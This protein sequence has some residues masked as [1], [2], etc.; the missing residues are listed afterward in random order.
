MPTERYDFGCNVIYLFH[1]ISRACS[2]LVCSVRKL[3]TRW[4]TTLATVMTNLPLG[5]SSLLSIQQATVQAARSQSSSQPPHSFYVP[6][7]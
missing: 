3:G 1:S 2:Y 6:P 5:S 4:S 7:Q